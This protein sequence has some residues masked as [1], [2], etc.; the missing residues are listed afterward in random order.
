MSFWRRLIH[1]VHRRSLWQVVGIYA[2]GAWIA[3]QVVLALHDAL[4]LPPWVPALTIVIIIAF[5]PVVVATAFVQEGPPRRDGSPLRRGSV[6]DPT[7]LPDLEM[8]PAA[9]DVAYV[10]S[11]PDAGRD[12]GFDDGLTAGP[13]APSAYQR[14]G[15]AHALPALLTWRRAGTAGV[16]TFLLL[17]TTAVGFRTARERGTLLAQGVIEAS[18]VIVLADFRSTGVDAALGEVVTEALRIDLLRSD[19]VRLAEPRQVAETL[20]RMQ[21]ASGQ[22]LDAE[23]AH[24]VAVR[25]GLKA[26]L[27]GEVG[28]LGGGYV[29]S[30]ELRAA[31]D[32]AVLA[33]FRATARDST[34]LIDAVDELS[35][36]VRD[37][38]GESLRTLRAGSP[39]ADVTTHSLPALRKYA[40]AT[41]VWHQT[42]DYLLAA[43]IMQEAVEA[44]STFAMAWRGLGAILVNLGMRP[45]ERDRAFTRAWELR[46]RL[47]ERERLQTVANYEAYVTNNNAAAI[48]AY[49]RLLALAPDDLPAAN[50]L[51]LSL[52][53]ERRY[54]EAEPLLERN[55]QSGRAAPQSWA[56]LLQVQYW[57]GREVAAESTLA[58]ARRAY[59]GNARLEGYAVQLAAA[60]QRWQVLDSMLAATTAQFRDNATAQDW[61]LQNRAQVALLEGRLADRATH[62]RA[63]RRRAAELGLTEQLRWLRLQELEIPLVV[64]GDRRAGLRQLE[65]AE[66]DV[67]LDSFAPES[68]PY[69]AFAMAYAEAGRF[70]RA[71]ALLEEAARAQSATADDGSDPLAWARAYVALRRGDPQPGIAVFRAASA[72]T[73]PGG[74]R[75]CGLPLLGEAYELAGQPDSARAVY[76]RFLTL[77]Y[78]YRLGT[79]A[80]ARPIVLQRVAELHEAAG[81]TTRAIQRYAEFVRLWERAD[82]VLQP[83]VQAARQRLV[84]LRGRG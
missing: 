13:D 26:V 41:R 80:V 45:A 25:D 83:R 32:G 65:Q 69:A 2:I 3:L 12:A 70:D 20:A 62:D 42:A 10:T 31:A 77:P 52:I 28:A 71:D 1:E 29:L 44:D 75:I 72:D 46:D 56:N 18:D 51:A 19:V 47:P 81:D 24:E 59:P 76:E 16:V 57:L 15:I 40:E 21:R 66:R 54:A 17:A 4:A 27:T 49:R 48:D 68:R 33:A 63:W 39:L 61:L 22:R 73:S 79:D 23:T 6:P 78:F 14:D 34:Q 30:A 64:L 74:C 58:A 82:P 55:V 36:Q 38:I 8:G 67:P 53:R 50:N 60:Q 43:G 37:R 7:L 84:A 5:L 35:H 11:A 9:D